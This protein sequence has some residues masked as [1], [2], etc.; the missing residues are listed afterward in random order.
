MCCRVAVLQ[1][2]R[3][4]PPTVLSKLS[5][6]DVEA[7]SREVLGGSAPHLGVGE[8]LAG[9]AVPHSQELCRVGHSEPETRW[10]SP[11]SPATSFNSIYTLF[12]DGLHTTYYTYS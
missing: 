12:P 2:G 6:V 3:A 5:S 4:C 1:L 9:L 11:R 10:V 8:A 7:P